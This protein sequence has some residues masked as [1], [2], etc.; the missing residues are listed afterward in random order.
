[1]PRG[2]KRAGA[3]RPKRP[4]Q[5]A[6]EGCGSRSRRKGRPRSLYCSDACLRSVLTGRGAGPRGGVCH[7]QRT[8]EHCDAPFQS[9][10]IEQRFCSTA[11]SSAWLR[12]TYGGVDLDRL[13]EARRR[14][15]ALRRAAGYRPEVGRWR[16]ICERDAWVCWICEA[17]IDWQLDPPHPWSGTV[18]H[19]LPLTCGGSD[20]D[21]NV[22]AAHLR[23]NS[24]R[25]RLP[26][27]LVRTELKVV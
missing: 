6:R 5:C 14:Q 11:C 15:S 8:C 12:A 3:G 4:F 23:C 21:T 7:I 9:P 10:V 13:R 2:G 19:L 17:P 20:D 26:V 22:R 16:R 24:A 25:G 18:D 1:M 27:E